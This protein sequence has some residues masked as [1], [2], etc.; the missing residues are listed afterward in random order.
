MRA[1]STGH[2][3]FW[4]KLVR[5]PAFLVAN[6]ALFLLIGV[7]TVR[8][9]YRGYTVDREIHALENQAATLEGRKMKLAELT[10]AVSSSERVELEARS[11]LGLKKD[12]EKVFVLTGYQATDRAADSSLFIAQSQNSP[13]N[14]ILWFNY[15]FKPQK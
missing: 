6:L 11:R 1:A 13:S 8:E 3:P 10:Q 9:T 12:G 7:S 2:G 15:F 14:A 5:W 4:K